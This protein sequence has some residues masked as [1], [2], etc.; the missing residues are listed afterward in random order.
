M[1][2]HYLGKLKIRNFALFMHVK[3]VSDVTFLSSIQQISVKCHKISAKI[4]NV[5]NIN[6]FLFVHSLS[7]TGL[8]LRSGARQAYG[9]ISERTLST[10][11]LTV[12]K[13]SPDMCP[14]KWWKFWTLF[15]NKLA[16]NLQF[17]MS[18]WFKWLLSIMSDFYCVDDWW[19]IGLP[20]IT[21][22]V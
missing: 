11:Q 7:L 10:M 16:N 2:L 13:A 12:K 3:R 20:C 18:F 21:S 19:S 1:L 14:C 17:F 8:K 4:N 9:P 5:Q 6:I 22:K 15:V